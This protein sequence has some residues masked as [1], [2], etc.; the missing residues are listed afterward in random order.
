MAS[1]AIMMDVEL[2]KWGITQ[3]GIATVLIVV[4]WNYR[5]DLKNQLIESRSDKAILI[6]LVTDVKIALEDLRFTI[7]RSDKIKSN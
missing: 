3:G 7:N 4:L 6:T 5:K 2:I 1:G